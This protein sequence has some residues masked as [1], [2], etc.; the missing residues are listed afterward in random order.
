MIRKIKNF[1]LAILSLVSLSSCDMFF[2]SIDA[3]IKGYVQSE[4]SDPVAIRGELCA[5]LIYENP[6][7]DHLEDIHCT[8]VATDTDGEFDLN[9]TENH[10]A[11]VFENLKLTLYIPNNEH[12]QYTIP[13]HIFEADAPLKAPNFE[14]TFKVR[15]WIR[16]SDLRALGTHTR[17]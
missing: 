14:G 10:R 3:R 6:Y 2:V 9:Y 17:W 1:S 5:T 4:R 11:G 16:E 8:E 13:G 7:G 12:P 15:F